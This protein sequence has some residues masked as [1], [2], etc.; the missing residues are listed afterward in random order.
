ML[1]EN[2]LFVAGGCVFHLNFKGFM[3]KEG[4]SLVYV[5]HEG[6]FT[7]FIGNKELCDPEGIPAS[8]SKFSE[9]VLSQGPVRLENAE[10]IGNRQSLMV[11]SFY[12][13]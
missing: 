2:T 3:Q 8:P 1:A 11:L 5:V 4:K 10:E 13:L 7:P 6:I 9:H 12:M